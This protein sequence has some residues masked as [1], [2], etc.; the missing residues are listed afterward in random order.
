MFKKKNNGFKTLNETVP[1]TLISTNVKIYGDIR[2]SGGVQLNGFLQGDIEAETS[3]SACLWITET[4]RVQGQVKVPSITVNGHIDGDVFSSEH[5]ELASNAVVNG[6][7]YYKVIEMAQGAV[8]N[9]QLHKEDGPVKASVTSLNIDT[10]FV[11]KAK[12]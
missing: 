1:D 6:N 8:V 7:V 2:F 3:A 5:L 4:G 11:S 9:G 12:S 10:D